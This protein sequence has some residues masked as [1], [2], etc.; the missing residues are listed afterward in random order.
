MTALA[1][2]ALEFS[3]QAVGIESLVTE[4]G[5]KVE[6]VDQVIHADDL[7]ALAGKKLETDQVSQ[8]VC[9]SQNLGRQPAFR[10]AYGLMLSPPFAPLAFW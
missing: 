6:A 2:F 3:A 7:T 10:A 9:Q 8:G 1:F 5:V 4:Q